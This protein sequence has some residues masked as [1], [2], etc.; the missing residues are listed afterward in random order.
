MSATVIVAVAQNPAEAQIWVDALRD[1]GIE[2]GTY[3]RGPAAAFGGGRLVF[4][5]YPVLVAADN[6]GSAR[7]VIAELG[8]A[9]MLSA[10]GAAG[11]GTFSWKWLLMPVAIVGALVAFLIATNST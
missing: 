9:S 10:V 3:Q 4:S 6:I 8:G 7:N 2:A 5:D 1:E 11:D